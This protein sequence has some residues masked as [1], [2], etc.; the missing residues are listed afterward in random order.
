MKKGTP[1]LVSGR[2]FKSM[3][4]AAKFLKC[5]TYAISN[6]LQTKNP[7]VK[8]H[9]IERVTEVAVMSL[10]KTKLRHSTKNCPVFCETTNTT[11][12]SITAAAR[13][14]NVNSWTMGL[15]MDKAGKFIDKNGNVYVR[16]RPMQQTSDRDY[17]KQSPTLDRI[18]TKHTKHSKP[19]K[20]TPLNLETVAKVIVHKEVDEITTLHNI[21]TSLANRR[22]YEEAA[23]IFK[24][25]GK[26]TD[27]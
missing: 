1:V 26:L 13:E 21:A 18:I 11:Y 22:K 19:N 25:L 10:P 15:K 4:K 8:G 12:D 6:A 24:V 17:G 2:K 5:K 27:D 9:K 7:E 23:S 20:T 14:A 16:S 3:V